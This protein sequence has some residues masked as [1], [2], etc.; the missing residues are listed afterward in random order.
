MQLND[1]YKK[2]K[3]DAGQLTGDILPPIKIVYPVLESM[4]NKAACNTR[5]D[6]FTGESPQEFV[7]W[8]REAMAILGK[9]LGMSKLEQTEP[10][11]RIDEI[12][13]LEDGIWREHLRLQ[14]EP[15]V[16]LTAY[17]LIPDN[18]SE[19]TPVVI[20]PHG[21]NGY[22][23]YSV[24]G[25]YEYDAVREKIDFY[26]CDYG[27]RLARLGYVAVCPDMRGFG[28][29]RSCAE[30]GMSPADAI[31]CECTRL[32][33]M[34][35]FLGI[36]VLG[37]ACWDLMR[38]TDYIIQRNMWDTGKIY[39]CGFSSGA[40]QALYLAALD[41]RI[42]GVILS[43]YLY[44]FRDSLIRMNENCSCNYIPHLL[45]HFDMGDIAGLICPRPLWIQ[46]CR[47]DRLNG[48]RGMKN[49]YE[50]VDIVRAIYRCNKEELRLYHEV[51][52]GR[53]RFHPE[54]LRTA[55]QFLENNAA[56]D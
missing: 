14:T 12:V 20:C 40:M 8:K 17:V 30:D 15:G 16:W 2:S 54:N 4:L 46:S 37:M 45:E 52:P 25:C 56:D 50:Q 1:Q 11:P 28:E 29:R 5:Q 35:E 41:G 53:H 22:G 55:M 36:T 49:V 24:A 38:L 6:S 51:C 43:G 13:R 26:Q 33:H 44:G 21:H 7:S 47:E 32:A 42:K 27:R 31:R 18:C 34:G 19:K 10:E 48:Y 39:V 23:K 3:Q 9:L